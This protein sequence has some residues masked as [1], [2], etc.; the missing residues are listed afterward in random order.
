[1]ANSGSTKVLAVIPARQASVRFPGKPL[2]NIAGKPMIQ[3]VVERVQAGHLGGS[4]RCRHRRRSESRKPWKPS[5]GK[6]F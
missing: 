6:R 1:M 2:A 4:D 5:A 3:H